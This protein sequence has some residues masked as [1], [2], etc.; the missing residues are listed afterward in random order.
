MRRQ[1]SRSRDRRGFSLPELLV[2]LGVVGI[3]MGFFAP[4]VDVAK[5]RQ[6]SAILE[7]SLTLSLAQQ[8]A[9][10]HGHSI[11]VGLDTARARIVLHEDENN[12][13]TVDGGED[14]RVVELGE[15]VAFGRGGAPLLNGVAFDIAPASTGIPT[16]RFFRNGA[17]SQEATLY[18]TSR[19]AA[20]S[21]SFGE[22]ARA[23]T[24]ERSTGRT[25]CYAYR[26]GA[27]APTC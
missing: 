18:L 10:L 4:R 25:T 27:W 21:G 26:N 3:I 19:R 8:K 9:V 13:R 2:I 12:D 14:V 15:G 17:A 1:S 11:R 5:F 22:D 20:L 7:L 24:L 16:L 6:D 23:L